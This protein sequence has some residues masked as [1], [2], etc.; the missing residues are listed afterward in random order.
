MK[1][2]LIT[3]LHIM[4]LRKDFLIAISA[5]LGLTLYNY[6]ANVFNII[7]T[8]TSEMYSWHYLYAGNT[9]SNIW[10]IFTVVYPFI[11]VIPFGFSYMQDK[12]SCLLAQYINRAGKKYYY[13]KLMASFVGSFLIIAVPF[14]INLMM[15]YFTFP[16]DYNAPILYDQML[17]G[18]NVFRET[19]FAAKPFADLFTHNLLLYNLL[20]LALLSLLSGL[21]GMFA[22]VFSFLV[23]R[24]RILI[25][26][27][28][29]AIF[30]IGIHASGSI[31]DMES[32]SYF[33]TNILDYVGTDAFY[34]QSIVLIG[35]FVFAIL[36]FIAI[37]FLIA[38]RRE[39]VL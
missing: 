3:Q 14:A 32:V 30:Q 9:N 2:A 25:F 21:L 4:V 27:P 8:G 22:M 31:Y 18:D 10:S 17:T 20:Y 24:L 37:S 7:N 1:K 12:K 23:H 16:H 38:V 5:V 35:S 19:V 15:C 13:A 28:L 29:F 11:V 26:I 33:N 6:L 34:G 39:D 36:L